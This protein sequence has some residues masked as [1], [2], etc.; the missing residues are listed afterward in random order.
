PHVATRHLNQLGSSLPYGPENQ[1]GYDFQHPDAFTEGRFDPKLDRYSG[2]WSVID[3]PQPGPDEAYVEHKLVWTLSYKEEGD[4]YVEGP[5]CACKPD[6]TLS[7]K[8]VTTLTGGKFEKFEVKSDGAMPQILANEGGAKPKLELKGDAKSSGKTKITA[9]YRDAKGNL[10]KSKAFEVNFCE[11]EGKPELAPNPTY[12]PTSDKEAYVYD[13]SSRGRL[14]IQAHARKVKLWS[15]GQEQ[16]LTN[17][18]WEIKPAAARQ[19]SPKANDTAKEVNFISES[20]PLN[21]SDFGKKQITLTTAPDACDCTLTSEPE[22]VKVFYPINISGNDYDGNLI[23]NPGGKEP[24]WLYYY[25]QTPAW[26]GISNS[27]WD[28]TIPKAGWLT[29]VDP[30][31]TCRYDFWTDVL[32][33]SNAVI[34][35]GALAPPDEP[36]D[37]AFIDAL[38]TCLRHEGQHRVDFLKWWG[39]KMERYPKAA[40]YVGWI[41]V[42]DPLSPDCDHD[43]VPND[44]EHIE[45]CNDGCAP[46]S[47]LKASQHS[48]PSVPAHLRSKLRD[49][50]LHAYNTGW[51]TW[52]RGQANQY[53]WGYPGNQ[54]D[55]VDCHPPK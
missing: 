48:C 24:N 47:S 1:G 10:Q 37:R 4:I 13:K 20:L 41:N 45:K 2:S 51:N 9:V 50:E 29:E 39:L 49:H 12:L 25:K 26:T 18:V 6:E 43:W 30:D 27:S 33:I 36:G 54:C 34:F 28:V 17:L 55:G 14:E 31:E 32:Y 40:S 23:T 42:L 3:P 5:K 22:K 53:D 8:G 38:A 11:L 35:K 44:F 21:N 7:Y 16:D 15:S 46:M 19:F 52:K